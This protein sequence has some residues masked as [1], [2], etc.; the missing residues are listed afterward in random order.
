MHRTMKLFF[1]LLL[2]LPL[3]AHYSDMSIEVLADGV[4]PQDCQ[5]IKIPCLCSPKPC[6]DNC[7]SQ[8]GEGA[9]GECTPDGCTDGEKVCSKRSYDADT[10]FDS[11]NHD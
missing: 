11:S 1:V 9:V 5:T 6:F 10:K 8:I 4:T 2:A 7:H 3:V